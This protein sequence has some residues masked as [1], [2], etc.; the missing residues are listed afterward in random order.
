[1]HSWGKLWARKYKKNLKTQ[2]PLLK[3]REQSRVLPM[4][5]ALPK[6]WADL[7]SHPSGTNRGL[8]PTFPRVRNQLA[9]CPPPSRELAAECFRS[10][11]CSRGPNK[12]LPEFSCLASYQFSL[13]KKAKSS[14]MVTKPFHS[15]EQGHRRKK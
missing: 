11:C 8:T 6:G 9:L 4:P 3:S 15:Q 12:A 10:R 14:S 13:T 7:L 2:L 1:M 5:P